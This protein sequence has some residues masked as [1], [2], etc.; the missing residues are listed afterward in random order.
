[1]R[2]FLKMENLVL[3]KARGHFI[4]LVYLVKLQNE[5][6]GKGKWFSLNDLPSSTVSFHKKY[7]I[8]IAAKDRRFQDIEEAKVK[9]LEI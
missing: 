9:T 3:F 1:L 5:P 4:S 7:I 2:E 6:T 8:P